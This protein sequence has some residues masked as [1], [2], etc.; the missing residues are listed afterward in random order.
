MFRSMSFLLTVASTPALPQYSQ[1]Q[2]NHPSR[3]FERVK[4]IDQENNA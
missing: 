1:S 4:S 3:Q 2:Q